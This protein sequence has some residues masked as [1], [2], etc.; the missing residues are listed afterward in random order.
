VGGPANDQVGSFA[1]W[2][3]LAKYPD[4]FTAWSAQGGNHREVCRPRERRIAGTSYASVLSLAHA[5]TWCSSGG[6]ALTHITDILFAAGIMVFEARAASTYDSNARKILEAPLNDAGSAS[7]DAGE[8]TVIQLG[9]FNQP[10]PTFSTVSD[11]MDL[12]LR[13][14]IWGDVLAEVARADGKAVLVRI[15][16]PL[17]RLIPTG[18]C[19]VTVDPMFIA[20]DGTN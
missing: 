12:E 19:Y 6:Y 4:I 7:D 3:L 15:A 8:R 20:D 5:M 9:D 18:I 11:D 2:E 10:E 13:A 17:A 14:D 16:T 1:W